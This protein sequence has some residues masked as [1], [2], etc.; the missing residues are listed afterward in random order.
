[1]SAASTISAEDTVSEEGFGIYHYTAD[2]NQDIE[3]SYI[4]KESM[5]KMIS[6]AQ[7]LPLIHRKVLQLRGVKLS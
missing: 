7:E 3:T 6:L 2:L 4:E 1:M 5:A